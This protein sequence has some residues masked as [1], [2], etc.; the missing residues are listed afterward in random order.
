MIHVNLF[1][2]FAVFALW[3]LLSVWKPELRNRKVSLAVLLGLLVILVVDFKAGVD[4]GS[5]IWLYKSILRNEIDYRNMGYVYLIRTVQMLTDR[6]WVSVL[7]VNLVCISLCFHAV[8]RNSRNYLLSFFLFFASG[9]FL[10]YYSS[11]VRQM[12]AAAVFLFAYYEYLP[13][14]KYLPYFICCLL[15]V[16]FHESGIVTFVIPLLYVVVKA[17]RKNAR[18][19][20]GGLAAAVGLGFVVVSFVARWI[21]KEFMAINVVAHFAMYL[22][23]AA[24]SITGLGMETVW[25][26]VAF[27]LYLLSEKDKRTDWD[28]FQIFTWAFAFAVYLVMVKFPQVSRLCDFIQIIML[29]SLPNWHEMIPDRKKKAA[30]LVPLLGL[31]FILLYGDMAF[32]LPKIKKNYPALNASVTEYPYIFIFDE[33]IIRECYGSYMRGLDE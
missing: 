13:K 6:Y 14:K 19:T 8:I 9:Y 27:G 11:G 17:Y 10:I 2:I 18:M 21:L 32:V 16:S 22:E 3:F 4:T 31:N 24:I 7:A 5:Y 33:P 25:F 15:S 23:N 30:A 20:I 29:V 1:L 26:G 28:L 12:L